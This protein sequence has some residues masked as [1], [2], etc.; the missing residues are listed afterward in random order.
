MIKRSE[1]ASKVIIYVPVRPSGKR[2]RGRCLQRPEQRGWPLDGHGSGEAPRGAPWVG[3]LLKLSEGGDPEP[4]RY[5]KAILNG[6]TSG[7][8]GDGMPQLS[9]EIGSGYTF[10]ILHIDEDW[11]Q[12]QV[13]CILYMYIRR[14]SLPS[15]LFV[16]NNDNENRGS[17][18]MITTGW[19]SDMFEN[20][21]QFIRLDLVRMM[22]ILINWLPSPSKTQN[23]LKPSGSSYTIST[24]STMSD[25][26]LGSLVHIAGIKSPLFFFLLVIRHK[27]MSL[28]MKKCP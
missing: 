15:P 19:S 11:L 4:I 5:Q 24:I 22:Q 27:F 26:L 16:N 28:E 2:R 7:R 9:V 14:T 23:F 1:E 18:T 20:R 10:F 17:L 12:N 21:G 6:Q 13:I 8:R 3:L 25:K